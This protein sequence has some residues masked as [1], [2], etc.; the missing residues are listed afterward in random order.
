MDIFLLVNNLLIVALALAMAVYATACRRTER[1]ARGVID[2]LTEDL[3]QAEGT[4]DK[5]N[6][7]MGKVTDYIAKRESEVAA[8]RNFVLAE[9]KAGNAAALKLIDD[10]VGGEFGEI[11]DALAKCGAAES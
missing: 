1:S 2:S 11:E 5:V 3:R 9:A 6:D 4:L 7:L 8:L 10:T